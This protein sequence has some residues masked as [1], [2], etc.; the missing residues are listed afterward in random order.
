ME[1]LGKNIL[2][3]LS[4]GGMIGFSILHPVSMLIQHGVKR[5]STPYRAL[6]FSSMCPYILHC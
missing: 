5:A 4:A 3:D 1:K 6:L 2:I